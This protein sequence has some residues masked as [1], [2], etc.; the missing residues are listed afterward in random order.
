MKIVSVVGIMVGQD[1]R[2]NE[3]WRLISAVDRAASCKRELD[4][5]VW[6]Q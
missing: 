1:A 4:T 5:A 6:I 2:V 3:A